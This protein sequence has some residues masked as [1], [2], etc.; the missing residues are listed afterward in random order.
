[1][2]TKYKKNWEETQKKFRGYWKQKNEGRPLMIIVAE[3]ENASP[4]PKEL[5]IQ[6][7][8]DQYC[9]PERMVARYRH[10]C[11]NHEFLAESFPN[12]SVDFG[13]GS[14]VAY[15]GSDIEFH[16]DT[17]WFTEAVEDWADA[18]KL[19]FAPDNKW[20]VK[21]MKIVKQCRELAGEDFYIPIPDLMENI[22]VL[23][24]LRGAQNTIFDLI[25]E[26]EEMEKR[27]QEV[28]D[29]YFEYYNRFYELTKDRSDNSSC[30]TVF[31]IWGDG[32]TGKIQCDFSAMMSPEQYREFI[33]DSLQQQ[34]KKL[35]N[36]LYHLDGP[37][38]I[39]HMDAIMEIE[40][41]DALQW[42]SG[43]HGPDGTLEEWYPIYDKAR[44]AGKS[45]WV[46]VY[47]GE[48]DDWIQNVDKLIKRYGSHSLLLYFDPMSM[49][50]AEKLLDYAEKHWSDIEGE[51][52]EKNK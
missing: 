40:E 48:V 52:S 28:T 27:I 26:P 41:I 29:V 31:Q 43:D 42:T 37:D 22:D 35:D 23:A 32:K 2:N 36:V 38:A 34:A 51:F 3:K 1:M 6:N 45:L 24:S 12:M 30:Y 50:D 16:K 9:N 8:E 7:E 33:V 46:K 15:L 25:D 5:E 47:S 39:R 49:T 21:H 44:L 17:V 19:T 11:E 18:P 20:F 14:V 10:F 4:L 13:P